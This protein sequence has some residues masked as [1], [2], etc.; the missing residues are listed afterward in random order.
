MPPVPIRVGARVPVTEAEGPGRRYALWL[1]GCSIRCPG[2]CNPHLFDGAGGEA[3]DA[4]T[5]LGEIAA[6]RDRVEG[7]TLLGGEPFEQAA[8]L[9]PLVRGTR[10]LGLSVIVFTGYTV[11][12]LSASRDP[13]V[14]HL[15]D[16]IDVLVDGRY[17][18]WRPEPRRLWVG[19]ANQRFHYLT[20]RYGPE[21][22][23][24]AA[25]GPRHTVE[26]RIGADGR[27]SAN[28]WPTLAFGTD[29]TTS[30]PS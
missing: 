10:D 4:A 19:S 23:V 15:L 22:E 20:G 12:A 27:W 2:C 3:C 7:V 8:G 11:E 9:V 18:R 26:V 29:H 14:R 13:A 30:D 5:L 6:V 24:P 17:E 21:I 28:G 1:Q 25:G 16:A